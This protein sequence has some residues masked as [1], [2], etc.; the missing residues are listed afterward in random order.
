[1]APWDERIIDDGYLEYRIHS[2]NVKFQKLVHEAIGE[3]NEQL[4]DKLILREHDKYYTDRQVDIEF[5]FTDDMRTIEK[6][7]DVDEPTTTLNYQQK[8]GDKIK[9]KIVIQT[10]FEPELVDGYKKRRGITCI[11]T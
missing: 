5:H 6:T 7:F 2:D 11:E 3:W 9:S 10:Y 8:D 4:G 1:M